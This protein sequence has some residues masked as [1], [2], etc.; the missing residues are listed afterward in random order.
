M[1]TSNI[2]YQTSQN[3]GEYIIYPNQN[4]NITFS[5]GASNVI[6]A[7]A[8]NVIYLNQPIETITGNNTVTVTGYNVINNV[9][10]GH[11]IRDISPEL[12]KE[13]QE[14]HDRAEKLIKEIVP[15]D[16]IA[17]MESEKGLWVKSKKFDDRW[18]CFKKHIPRIGVYEKRKNIGELCIIPDE[19][20]AEGDVIAAKLALM[21]LDE[22]RLCDTAKWWKPSNHPL[23][24]PAA[25][26]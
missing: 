7:A 15:N 14:A 16:I 6:N 18:Y 20:Y 25:I 22:K 9:F 24:M 17:Q 10:F 26:V 3:T 8:S 19:S 13:Q 11:I 21:F 5:A 1:T 2:C 23:E 12:I 4:Q